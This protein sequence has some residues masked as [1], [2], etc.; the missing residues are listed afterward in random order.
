MKKIVI[1]AGDK[2]GDLYGGRLSKQLKEKFPSVKIYSF[3][4]NVLAQHS[5]QM[6]NLLAHSVCG[7]IEV[8][9]SLKKL[10]NIF[11][12]VKETI[13][14]LKPDLIILIDFP[15]FN[16]RLAKT[17]NKKFPLFYYISP[18]VWAWRKKRVEAIKK[19]ADKMIV[20][21]KFEKAFY[22]NEG[23]DALYFG[24]P[25]L[26]IIEEVPHRDEHSNIEPLKK[27]IS[28][29]PGSRENE[30]KRHLPVMMKTKKILQK[31]LKGYQFQIIRP[32]NL[33]E[34]F[35]EKFSPGMDIVIHSYEA[36]KKSDFIIACS[37]TATVELAILEIPYIIIYKL[38]PLSWYILK[39]MVKT[40]FVGMINIL[41]GRKIVDEFLQKQAD[42][43]KIAVKTIEYLK[44]KEK[45]SGLKDELKKIKNILS[46]LNATEKFA[47]FIG[48]Y[49]KLT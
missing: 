5:Q 34:N 36:I 12:K 18:Q 35:Y 22:K 32:P 14:D 20:L 11:K 3:G 42:P 26:E 31:E 8:L 1:V 37:G 15:D 38:N 28:F 41:A 17:L 27:I 23:M 44:N 48:N 43:E 46:P 13:L 19:Y 40:N 29:L 39:K 47:D 7:I 24:H 16:L 25:L 49:L 9:S 21:F 4:G 6:I 30:V 45:Y 10:L 2:S 33:E